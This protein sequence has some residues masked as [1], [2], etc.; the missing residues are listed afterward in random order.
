MSH[1]QAMAKVR[2]PQKAL[3]HA[4]LAGVLLRGQCPV[5]STTDGKDVEQPLTSLLGFTVL[6]AVV[7]A[8]PS[9][10]CLLN[11]R[12]HWVPACFLL[13]LSDQKGKC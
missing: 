13:Q 7:R 6:T 2:K 9:S 12:A 3:E 1:D 8:K 4:P 5:E 11:R 10:M